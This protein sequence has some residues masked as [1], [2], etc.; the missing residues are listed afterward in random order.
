MI[1]PIVTNYK[2]LRKPCEEVNPN[3]SVHSII[4]DL[5]NTLEHTGGFG[6]SANQIN[7]HKK[8]SYVKIPKEVNKLTK[9]LE[10]T[11]L[12]LINAII[13]EKG[14]PVRF[15]GEGCLS[16][17]GL[18]VTTKRYAF[19]VVRFLD[20][21]LKEQVA[22]MNDLQAVAISHE[23]DHQNSVTLLERKWKAK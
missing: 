12:V 9:K 19:I 1:K 17:P 8:I 6:I 3:E 18:R 2:E 23:I 10:Y 21:N 15:V 13:E 11:E 14:T 7:I 5:K 22:V 20:E 4:T 16:F